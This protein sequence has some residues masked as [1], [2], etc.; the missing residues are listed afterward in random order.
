MTLHGGLSSHRDRFSFRG[1]QQD[2]TVER[3]GTIFPAPS[4]RDRYSGARPKAYSLRPSFPREYPPPRRKLAGLSEGLLS[5]G[6]ST[7]GSRGI[8]AVTLP[9][10]LAAVHPY[11]EHDD[12][13]T[14]G[15]RNLRSRLAPTLRHTHRPCLQPRQP[16]RS[17]EQDVGGFV[18][19]RAHHRVAAH[20]DSSRTV[21]LSGLPLAR[22]ES[23]VRAHRV[24]ARK[25]RKHVDARPKGQRSHRTHPRDRHQAAAEPVGA[26]RRSAQRTTVIAPV[27]NSRLMSRWPIFDTLP[28]RDLP[29]VEC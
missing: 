16:R 11:A 17:P 29:P 7:S 1:R 10:E 14:A 9:A 15:E 18:E 5:L 27:I 12:A 25:T 22:S 23:E 20:G 6:V 2:G 28:R 8:R 4:Q 19:R 26:H 13:E 3:S 21:D 24:R